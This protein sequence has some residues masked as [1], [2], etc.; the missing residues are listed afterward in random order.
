MMTCSCEITTTGTNGFRESF[1]RGLG[2]YH[3]ITSALDSQNF[4]GT[5]TVLNQ[6]KVINCTVITK[7]RNKTEQPEHSPILI[8]QEAPIKKASSWL[9]NSLIGLPLLS[10]RRLYHVCK[11]LA[12]GLSEKD[13][14]KL[15]SRHGVSA[16]FNNS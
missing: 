15:I 3:S 13:Y 14:R 10:P 12:L 9:Y 7:T 16:G 11:R 8:D 6:W 2:Q 4:A 5:R 1:D